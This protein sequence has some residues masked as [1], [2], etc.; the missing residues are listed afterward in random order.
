MDANPL[1]L[2]LLSLAPRF[3]LFLQIAPEIDDVE[4]REGI[5]G[6]RKFGGDPG[7]HGGCGYSKSDQ[8]L[9]YRTLVGF[10]KAP[11]GFAEDVIFE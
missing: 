6:F 10:E 9:V 8:L 1:P 11:N 7:L 5:N 4:E 3:L 2:S